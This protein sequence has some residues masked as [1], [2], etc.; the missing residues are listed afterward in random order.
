MVGTN[1]DAEILSSARNTGS[2]LVRGEGVRSAHGSPLRLP[3]WQQGGVK[4][5]VDS[6]YAG[7]ADQ[8]GHPDSGSGALVR[9]GRATVHKAA[10]SSH[11]E[12]LT[13]EKE[14]SCC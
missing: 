2:R 3:K 9:K 6:D 10:F 1:G 4:L 12:A 11:K 8:V 7:C 14:A 13:A 5:S